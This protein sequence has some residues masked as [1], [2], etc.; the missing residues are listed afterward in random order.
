[1]NAL[2]HLYTANSKVIFMW[3]S[4]IGV[5]AFFVALLPAG[6]SDVGQLISRPETKTG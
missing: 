1:M 6:E 4:S 5:M 2:E 3:S